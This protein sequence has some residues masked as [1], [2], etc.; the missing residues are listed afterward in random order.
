MLALAG[1]GRAQAQE[2]QIE[3]PSF[4]FDQ[5]NKVYRYQEARITLGEMTLE[6]QDIVIDQKTSTIRAKGEVRLRSGSMFISADK[7]DIDAAKKSAV[8]TNARVY[9]SKTGFYLKADTLNIVTPDHLKAPSCTLTSCPP[10]LPGWHLAVGGIDYHSDAYATGQNA[11]LELGDFPVFW[12]PFF[13]WPTVHKRHSGFL[14]PI[15]T[16]QS[17]ALPRFNL[18]TRLAAPYFLDLGSDQDL[19]FLPESI[20]NRGPAL[21]L[22][23]RYAFTGDQLGRLR[24]WGIQETVRRSPASENDILPAGESAQQ[25]PYISRGTLDWGHNQSL[26]QG[27]RVL[28]S[29]T[30]SS[31]GQVRDEYEGIANYR[32]AE[33]YQASYTHQAR[34]GE[35]GLTA[36]HASE[37]TAESIYANSEAFTDGKNRP[38]ILPR[39]TYGT[40][41][42]PLESLPFGLELTTNAV[43]FFTPNDVSGTATLARPSLELPLNL[44]NGFA[45]RGAI[46]RQFVDYSGL[47]G[48]DILTGLPTPTNESYA[49]TDGQA[50]LNAHLA[51]VYRLDPGSRWEALKHQIVP[52]LIYEEVEDVPQPLPDRIVRA[53]IA[54]KLLTLRLDN[55]LLARA[56]SYSPAPS[57][58]RQTQESSLD[59]GFTTFR[60]SYVPTQPTLPQAPERI[61]PQATELAHLDLIQRYNF[62][63]E[64]VNP[65]IHGPPLPLQQ[66]TSPGQPLLPL[67]LEGGLSAYGL[68]VDFDLHYHHQ[69]QRVTESAVSLSGSIRPHSNLSV[70]YTQREFTY[71]SPDNTL[72]PLGTLLAFGGEVEGTDTV[73]VGLSSTIDLADAP[74]PLNQRAFATGVFLDFHPLCYALRLA[75]DNSLQLAQKNGQDQYYTVQRITLTFTLGGLGSASQSQVIAP[76]GLK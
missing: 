29:A 15:I 18:G 2:V 7:A 49:Q 69:L 67:I 5:V 70:S 75:V 40:G 50:E 55:N 54:E 64:T 11:T 63:Q 33:V 27:G 12:F 47:T 53:R 36:E 65:E 57:E 8:V 35:V 3:A 73:S 45:F 25:N 46:S 68:N 66:E 37:F 43:N 6:A 60:G 30:A 17:A 28:A 42:R 74:A 61:V 22:E 62:L 32:P 4:Q 71:R 59:P 51:R 20:E 9:D 10:L 48:T 56:Q 26:G 31:D 19:T 14:A 58:E 38:A 23:Y 76:Q 52:R 24:V 41:F 72:Q 1:M 21:G 16:T 44:G 13:A 39:L 34:W